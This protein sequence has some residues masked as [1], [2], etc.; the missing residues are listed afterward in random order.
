MTIK[1]ND[2][3]SSS[4]AQQALNTVVQMERTSIE[5]SLPPRWFDIIMALVIGTLVFTIAA[6]LRDYYFVPIVAIPLLLA[7]RSVKAQALPMTKPL[8]VKGIV[9]MLSLIIIMLALISGA[10]VLKEIYGLTWSPIVVGTIA[11]LIVY[12][13]SVVE[14]SDYLKKINAE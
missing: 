10:R 5:K 3:I 4:D 1:E 9:A 11:T 6:G 8:S 2:K 12:W 14:R 7:A 13:L